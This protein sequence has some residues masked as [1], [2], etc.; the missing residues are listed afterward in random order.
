[1]TTETHPTFRMGKWLNAALWSA[2]GLIAFFFLWGAY[3]KLGV[4]VTEAAKMMPW[5]AVHPELARFTGM[6]DLAGG[7]GILLPALLKI[8]PALT[9]LAAKGVIV[10]QLLAMGFH[11]M[12]GEAMVLPMNLL[13]LG[14]AAFVLWGRRKAV[15]VVS[16]R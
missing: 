13:L 1:M 16:M 7:I 4:L 14:L 5:V 3:M 9:L 2:Q 12:R 6:V 11:L 15:S 10:L 8:K